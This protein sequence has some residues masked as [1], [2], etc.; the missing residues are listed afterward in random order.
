MCP[1]LDDNGNPIPIY[2]EALPETYQKM[3]LSSFGTWK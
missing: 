1:V 2:K 3:A